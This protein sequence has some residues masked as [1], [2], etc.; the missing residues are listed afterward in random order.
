VRGLPEGA[1]TVLQLRDFL[2]T[3]PAIL[4]VAVDF[5]AALADYPLR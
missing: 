5:T 2:A 4:K 3:F 1:E